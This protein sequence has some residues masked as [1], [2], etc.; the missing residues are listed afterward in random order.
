VL[1]PKTV[2]ST[3]ALAA[4][5]TAC[6]ARSSDQLASDTSGSE[7]VAST[8]SDVESLG[9]SFV[10]SDG[11]SVVTQ[12]VAAGSEVT[13]GNPGFWFL[14][15]G[16]LQITDDAS[17]AQVTYAFA[18][19]TGPLG[20]VELTGIV[21]VGWQ[22]ASSQLTLNFS[23]TDFHI[24][25]AIIASWQATAV[26][27]AT[28]NQRSMTWDAQL[29]GTTGSGRQFT[30]TNDKTLTWTVGVACLGVT[31]QSTGDIAGA[32]LQTT[33]VTWQR[34]ADACPQAGSQIDVKNLGNGDSIDIDYDGGPS[35]ELTADGKS[36][37][38]RLA[39]GS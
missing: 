39:C 10:G 12:P 25:R 2:L 4:L 1:F 26:I 20:L 5:S 8:E 18:G 34:C 30:R 24:N 3:L 16:C 19:C 13:T 15:A 6:A 21:T 36:V 17:N 22:V 31:G 14:P 7:D 27:T 38:I 33:I 35:A 9:T 23:A 11:Q 29:T 37:A 28:G 32:D